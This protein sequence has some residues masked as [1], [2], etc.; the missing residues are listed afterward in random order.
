MSESKT[1]FDY[2]KL[3]WQKRKFIFYVVFIVG[4]LSIGISLLLP[5]YYTATAVIMAPEEQS[6]GFSGL[7]GMNLAALGLGNI[8]GGG[9]GDV[10]RYIAI[11]KSR[12][13]M[14]AMNRRFNF[15]QRYH[16]KNLEETIRAM[17][18][19][20]YYRV[21][22]ENQLEIT[23]MD[24]DQDQ[25]ADMTNYIVHCIDSLNIALATKKAMYNRD[26]VASR[27]KIAL[28][29]LNQVENQLTEFMK[30][31]SLVS[32]EDQVRVAVE[33]AAQFKAQIMAKEVELQL[34]ENML[35]PSNPEVLRVKKELA[36]LRQQ[37]HQFYQNQP[38]DRL[39]PPFNGIQEVQKQYLHLQRQAMYYGKL[40]EFLGPQYEQ[41]KIEAAKK[42]PTIQVLDNAV[43]PERKARPKRATFVILLTFAGFLFAVL[44]IVFKPRVADF[45]ARLKNA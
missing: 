33:Q 29:S 20:I 12:T 24:R 14:E 45:F 5:K 30:Q 18:E 36:A 25:V 39:F 28:D 3:L 34:K 37:Y 31:H 8:L 27:F 6:P 43:R 23:F 11:L 42:I 17:R 40:I 7:G 22:E 38:G 15:Q 32:I 19:Y 35:K 2:F 26:F 16:A 4:L 9:S 1:F 21:G 13:L 10:F 44:Y 41:A